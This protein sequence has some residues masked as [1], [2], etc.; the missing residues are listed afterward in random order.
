MSKRI[1]RTE[2][3]PEAIGPY[4]Q[5]VVAG[6]FVYTAGQLALDPKTGQLVPGDVRIQTKRVM[7]N[8]KAILESAGT[9]F[10]NVVKTT[11]FL[12]DMN[13]FGAMNEIYGSYFQE[14]PPVRSTFQVAKLPRDGAVEI[15][16]VA[17]LK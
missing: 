6:G 11:V 8:I 10:A 1:V 12:R 7:E 5:G 14:N 9:S 13:D 15:E 16:V 2:E 3:A 17:L 4:S